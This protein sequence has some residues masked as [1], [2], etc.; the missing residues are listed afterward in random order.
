QAGN[1]SA[2]TGDWGSAY[3]DPFDLAVPKFGT[4]ARGNRS[5]Y[6]NPRVD[7]LFQ[8]ASTT[9]DDGARR[10]AYFEAQRILFEDAPWVFGYVLQNIEAASD[11]VQGWRPAADN[12]ESMH[13]AWVE[14]SDT[15]VVGMR[16]DNLLTFDPAMFRSRETEAV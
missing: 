5:F 11:A 4:N 1:R 3:F 8:I 9:L 12:S 16:T 14:G 15:L 6:S 7:E 2:S 10:E 13:D